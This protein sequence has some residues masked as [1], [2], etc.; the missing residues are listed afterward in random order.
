MNILAI[1]VWPPVNLFNSPREC[2]L[3][4]PMMLGWVV[5]D[6]VIGFVADFGLTMLMF[7]AGYECDFRRIHGRPLRNATF[8]WLASGVL[9][10]GVM[11]SFRGFSLTAVVVGLALTTTALG[12]ILPTVRDTGALA[13]PFGAAVLAI[14]TIGE[15]AP[16][17]AVSVMLNGHNPMRT[18]LLLMGFVGLAGLAAWRA[19]RPRSRRVARLVSATLGSSV[20]FVVRLALLI[21]VAMV[22]VAGEFGLDVLLGAF[23]AGIVFRLFLD[24][25][26]PADHLYRVLRGPCV[27]AVS[28]TATPQL[29][30][31]RGARHSR[32]AGHPSHRSSQHHRCY[33]LR[34]GTW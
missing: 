2:A 10:L 9:A 33:R 28:A 32:G 11:V 21:V 13:G 34:R 26:D 6:D 7:L 29:D 15:F 18:T 22:W 31:R 19:T 4:G 5:D 1:A 27:N 23:A 17:V 14:G 30:C 16:I 12:I 25:G 8:G 24:T 3:L 20:Q